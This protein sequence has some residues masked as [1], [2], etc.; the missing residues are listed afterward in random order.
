M[1]DGK[2][3]YFETTMDGVNYNVYFADYYQ[4]VAANETTEQLICGV[5][6]DKNVDMKDGKYI[7]PRHPE[8]DLSILEGTVKYPVFAVAVQA[9]GFDTAARYGLPSAPTTIL[10]RYRHQLAVIPPTGSRSAFLTLLSHPYFFF[11]GSGPVT[12]PT[13]TRLLPAGRVGWQKAPL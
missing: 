13:P 8:A 10:G 12:R 3:N 9:E 11:C 2:W 6:L 5:Y 1:H 4:P 7:D